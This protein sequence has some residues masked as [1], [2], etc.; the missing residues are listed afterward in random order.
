M[1]TRLSV[2][3]SRFSVSDGFEDVPNWE[4]ATVQNLHG[5]R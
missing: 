3:G 2:R 5:D 1:K 4:D